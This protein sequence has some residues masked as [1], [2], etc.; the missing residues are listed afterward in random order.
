MGADSNLVNGGHSWVH[1]SVSVGDE[2]DVSVLVT[3]LRVPH[4]SLHFVPRPALTARLQQAVEHPLTLVAAPAGSGK[5]TLLAAWLHNAPLAR[6]WVSLDH[7]DDDPTRFWSAIL[8]ALDGVHGG[9]GAHALLLRSAQTPELDR[10]LTAVINDLTALSHDVVLVLDDY[11]VITAQPIHSSL[12][13]LLDHL[14]PHLHLIIATRA[15]PPLPLA[16]LRGRG[17]LL[18]IRSAD[19]R[20]GR[21]E[22][23]T[24]LARLSGQEL[25]AEDI[26][27]LD[28]RI[29]G[30]AAGLQ[31]A[32]LALQGQQDRATFLRAFS[33]THRFV[34]DYL[35]DEVLLQQ[36]AE[37]QRFLLQTGILERLCASLCEAI[38][39]EPGGQAMLERLDAAQL[40]LLPQDDERQWYRYHHLFADMLRQRVQRVQPERV[41]LL[42]QQASSWYA[43][44]DL[45]RDAVHHAIAAPDFEQAAQLIEQTADMLVKRGEVA[46]LRAWLARLPQNL[47][48]ARPELCLWHGWLLAHDGQFV[49]AEQLLRELEDARCPTSSPP[50]TAYGAVATEHDDANGKIN[51]AGRVAAIRAFIAFRQG[52]APRTVELARQALAQLSADAAARGLAAWNLGIAYLWCGDPAAGAAALTEARVLSHA[53]G[54]SYAAI[55][56]TFELAQMQTRQGNLHRAE[57]SYWQALDLV[58]EHGGRLP[59]TGPIYVGRGELRR[60]W[61]DLD[62]ASRDLDAGITQ[63]QQMGQSAMLLLG[64]ISL[65]RVKQAQ[66]DTAG[67]RVLIQ[68]LE[69]HL[70]TV[71]LPPV[72]ATQLAAWHARLSLQCG[73]P[74]VAW[75]WVQ[76]WHRP[77]DEALDPAHEIGYLTWARVLIAQHRPAEPWQVLEQLLHLAEEQGRMGSVME[78]L[79][80]QALS[81]CACGDEAAALQRL[82]RALI[83]AEPEGYIR[84][85]VDEGAPMAKLLMRMRA[86]M[87]GDQHGSRRYRNHLLN[88][89]AGVA[90]G[91]ALPSATI[92]RSSGPS[93]L[94]EPLSERELEVVR[95]IIAGCSNQEIADQLV[96]A[97]S[98]VKWH[99]NAIYG[100]LQVTSRTKAIARARALNI[101]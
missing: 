68:M 36:P 92:V 28:T 81:Q 71:H 58:A 39:G 45:L 10:L 62:L 70:H 76:D 29:E 65:A 84:L 52:N 34:V 85:F 20:F 33:G 74:T 87:P 90:D 63:C 25:S 59:V 61:N 30:W 64:Y 15:D 44:H 46:T 42:H 37:V 41:A 57:W 79:V 60:E 38:T 19:L 47:V 100:K 96:I 95:L 80:L 91:D 98:T 66:G 88:L 2:P 17:Q 89:L 24:F 55:M 18:E 83:L 6:A 51:Y 35:T 4:P 49:G 86:R 67:A 8:A 27:A 54:N 101:G 48:R 43:R 13:F 32:G 31:L 82:S 9:L 75:R 53:A 94:V 26:T 50:T 77:I 11:H 22:A 72:N 14:P 73:D 16:R 3:K 23:G 97:V 99:V 93:S 78:I 7:G 5:T 12:I 40:F 21:E 69:E 1:P 56:I